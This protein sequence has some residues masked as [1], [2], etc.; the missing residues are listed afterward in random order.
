LSEE[1]A[2]ESCEICE[3][4]AAVGV[5][6]EICVQYAKDKKACELVKKK[7]MLG[8]IKS[9]EEMVQEYKKV[10]PEEAHQLLEEILEW[11]EEKE[12][13]KAGSED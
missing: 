11:K 2:P 1:E 7:V 13:R 6:F 3:D 5:A 12:E 9:L 4:S 8:E 10:T